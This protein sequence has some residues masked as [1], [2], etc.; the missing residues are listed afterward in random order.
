MTKEQLLEALP[1]GSGIDGD[2]EIEN[3][4]DAWVCRNAY[5]MM[6]ASGMYVSWKPFEVWIPKDAPLDF[7]LQLA[8]EDGG[9]WEYLCDTIFWALS[10]ALDKSGSFLQTGERR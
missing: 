4:G 5:H 1:H 7:D 10:Q 3:D 8:D 9:L 6:N 2:W